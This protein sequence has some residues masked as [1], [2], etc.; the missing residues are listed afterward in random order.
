MGWYAL[1]THEDSKV[2]ERPLPPVPGYAVDVDI[3]DLHDSLEVL[4]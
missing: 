2:A 4:R 3:A 1:R